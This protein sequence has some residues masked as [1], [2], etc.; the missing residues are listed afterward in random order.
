MNS[1]HG[2][3]SDRLER[4]SSTAYMNST[5]G[6]TINRGIPW[7]VLWVELFILAWCGLVRMLFC[8]SFSGKRKGGTPFFLALFR[9][10][11]VFFWP[12]SSFSHSLSFRTSSL[13]TPHNTETKHSRFDSSYRPYLSEHPSKHPRRMRIHRTFIRREHRR[14]N[15][16]FHQRSVDISRGS[17][18][19]LLRRYGPR[20]CLSFR[21]G[22]LR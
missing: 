4:W 11:F 8:V 6:L 19:S 12:R 16:S 18:R 5:I 10:T 7:V 20:L 14:R 9:I 15:L 17:I 22:F 1:T 13:P 2:L 21:S 3:I